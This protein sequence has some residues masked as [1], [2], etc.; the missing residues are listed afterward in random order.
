MI[1]LNYV[2]HRTLLHNADIYKVINQISYQ[3][4]LQATMNTGMVPFL[5]SWP[6]AVCSSWHAQVTLCAACLWSP[7]GFGLGPNPVYTVHC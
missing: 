3:L 7:S 6:L 2:S 1:F 5:S 4:D